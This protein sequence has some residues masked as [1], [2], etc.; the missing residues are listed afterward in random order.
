MTGILLIGV[1]A[2]W[3]WV[4]VAVARW[5]YRKVRSPR[6]RLLAGF[7]AGTLTLVFPVLDEVVGAWQFHRICQQHAG[8][9]IDEANAKDRSVTFEGATTNVDTGT[10]VEIRMN[11]KTYRDVETKRVLAR[12]HVVKAKG[13]LLIRTLGISETTAPLVFPTYCAPRNQDEWRRRLNVTV[14][15]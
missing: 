15:N 2:A 6:I 8:Q 12:H 3:L 4:S 10:L 13:G 1:F 14:V 5:A 9:F 7:V 11:T